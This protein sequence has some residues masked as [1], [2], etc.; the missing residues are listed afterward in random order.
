[1]LPTTKKFWKTVKRF[2]SDN[3]IYTYK[4]TLIDNDTITKSDD[5]ASKVLNTFFSNIVRH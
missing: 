5:D 1:M 4:I 3:I 2:L